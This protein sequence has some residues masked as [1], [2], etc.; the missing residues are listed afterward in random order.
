MLSQTKSK[1]PRLEDVSKNSYSIMKKL[2]CSHIERETKDVCLTMC[3]CI[4]FVKIHQ[5]SSKNTFYPICF[6]FSSVVHLQYLYIPKVPCDSLGRPKQKWSYSSSNDKRGCNCMFLADD[7]LSQT[8]KTT[9]TITDA[10][11]NLTR[12]AR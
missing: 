10:F 2:R 4:G 12:F 7:S 5:S 11:P 8:L 1:K 3:K 6:V 9:F